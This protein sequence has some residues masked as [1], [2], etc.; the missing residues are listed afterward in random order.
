VGIEAF[1][2]CVSLETRPVQRKLS[3][4]RFWMKSGFFEDI[5]FTGEYERERFS[6]DAA[7]IAGKPA[8]SGLP[9]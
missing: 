6:G 1:P 2:W 8:V 4:D 3:H 7:P 9:Q 5:F